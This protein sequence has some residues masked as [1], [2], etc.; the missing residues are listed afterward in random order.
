MEQKIDDAT[1][2]NREKSTLNSILEEKSKALQNENAD[3]KIELK[4]RARFPGLHK[5]YFSQVLSHFRWP[6]KT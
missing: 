4:V 5:G 1:S 3:L 6:D 2:E